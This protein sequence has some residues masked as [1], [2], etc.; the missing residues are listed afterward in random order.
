MRSSEFLQNLLAAGIARGTPLLFATLGEML[1]DTA[2]LRAHR[3][4]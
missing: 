2:L 3:L 1:A 4:A